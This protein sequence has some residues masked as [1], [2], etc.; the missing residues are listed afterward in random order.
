MEQLA[1]YKGD[2]WK[3]VAA[4]SIHSVPNIITDGKTKPGSFISRN[5]EAIS[6]PKCGPLQTG[7]LRIPGPLLPRENTNFP[8]FFFGDLGVSRDKEKAVSPPSTNIYLL[9]LLYIGILRFHFFKVL[10]F[11]KKGLKITDLNSSPYN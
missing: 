10:L 7:L 11:F 2:E 3:M 1:Y 5:A 6:I 9:S 8:I 4:P